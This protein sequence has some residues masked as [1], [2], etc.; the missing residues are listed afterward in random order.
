MPNNIA[1]PL[2][3]IETLRLQNAGHCDNVD[4][5]WRLGREQSCLCQKIEVKIQENA[6][7]KFH[8]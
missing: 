7:A 2:N 6:N 1:V 4:T 5:K 3:E 8:S